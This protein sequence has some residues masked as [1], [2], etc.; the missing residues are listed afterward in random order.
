MGTFTASAIQSAFVEI[1]QDLTVSVQRASYLTSLAIAVL[2]GAPLF[3]RPLGNSFGRR[4]VFL[5]S[6]VGSVVGNVGCAKSASYG[7]M[8]L[9]RAI[10]AFFISP[11]GAMGSAVVAESFFKRDRARCMGVWAL[12]VTL[13]IP[14][15]PFIFGF[16]ALRVGYRWIY[17]ILAITNAVQLLLYSFLGHE[18][19]YLRDANKPAVQGSQLKQGLFSFR[20][21][22]KTPITLMDFLKPLTFA[23]RPCVSVPAG[24]YAMIFLWGSAMTTIE[25]PQVYPEKFGLNTQEVGLQFLGVIIGSVLGEQVGGFMSDRWMR[26]RRERQSGEAPAPEFRLWLAYIGHALTICGVVVFAVQIG[27]AAEGNWNVTPVVGA[28]IAAAGNQIVTT[29]N[30]TYAVDCYRT[31]AASVGVFITLVRQVWGFIGPFWFPQMFENVGWGGGAGIAVGLMV[32]ASVLPTMVLQW[33]GS[34]WR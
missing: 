6:L 9:C 20:R 25:I 8:G 33:R 34:G 22:D 14:G 3:W 15:A 7:T 30:I 21:I 32:A 1:A 2:G 16:V 5:V 19:L 17:W 24:A 13:G 27:H 23:L 10:T 31:E 4:P 12:M 11:A 26:Q 29:V 28:A 18:T